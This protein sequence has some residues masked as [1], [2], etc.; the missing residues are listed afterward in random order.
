MRTPPASSASSCTTYRASARKCK[1]LGNCIC[2]YL[3]SYFNLEVGRC[4]HGNGQTNDHAICDYLERSREQKTNGVRRQ[5]AFSAYAYPILPEPLFG[6][7]GDAPW[8]FFQWPPNVWADLAELLHSLWYI[9]YATVGKK[10]TGWGQATELWSYAWYSP[11]PIFERNRVFCGVTC[12]HWQERE[13]MH[14]SGQKMTRPHLTPEI[15]LW[16]FEVHLR[17][18]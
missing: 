18:L 9:L 8:F 11:R 6:Q 3:Q 17:S 13:I 16:P 14:D 2:M 4:G 1:V 15:A 12:S 10:M 7:R 5:N